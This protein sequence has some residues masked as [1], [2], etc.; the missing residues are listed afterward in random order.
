MEININVI[1]ILLY[2][3]TY[4][5]THRHIQAHRDADTVTESEKGTQ[6]QTQS[7]GD[8]AGTQIRWHIQIQRKCRTHT[9]AA[10][11]Q[12]EHTVHGPVH[13]AAIYLCVCMCSGRINTWL[14]PFQRCGRDRNIIRAARPA[15][16][17]VTLIRWV[18]AVIIF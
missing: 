15:P 8:R 3:M 1:M 18:G 10:A 7:E 12:A 11:R 9:E 17:A 14:Q 2:I 16:C 4:P 13:T 5:H 6:A